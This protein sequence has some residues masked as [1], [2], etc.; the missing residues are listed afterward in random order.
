MD[1][2]GDGQWT[3][4]CLPWAAILHA[5]TG[6]GEMAVLLLEIFRR[7][8]VRS[9]YAS[10]HDA[11]LHGFTVMD[12][13][14]DIMQVEAACAAA[15][16]IMELLAHTSGGV[17]RLFP[18]VPSAWREVS[19]EGIR[20]EGGFLVS[21]TMAARRVIEVRVK[22]ESEG[23]LRL[24]NPFDGPAR[25]TRDGAILTGETLELRLASGE[26]LVLTPSVA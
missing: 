10:T 8:F 22:A 16:A 11:C 4:W 12:G 26:E 13:R 24:R 7:A 3:G 21:T 9:G 23:S 14:P 20:V 1:T 25:L 15:A 17:L 5:R 6:N 19:F 2:D 18:A